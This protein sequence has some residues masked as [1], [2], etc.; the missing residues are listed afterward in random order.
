MI[1]TLMRHRQRADE[2][3]ILDRLN[4]QKRQYVFLTLHRPSNVDDP[5]KLRDLLDA[6]GQIS[7][8]LPLIFAIHPR[9]RKNVASFGLQDRLEAHPDIRLQ[10][11]FGYLECLKL[12][13]D[14]AAVITDSGGMQEETTILGVPCLTLRENTERPATITDGTNRLVV[15]GKQTILAAWRQLND[16]PP[17]ADRKPKLWDGNAAARITKVIENHT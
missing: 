14:A 16:S 17:P 11:P 2:S 8:E 12:M 7:T 13:N 15:P 1:D 5:A 9:T 10:E 4:L 3:D 6:L